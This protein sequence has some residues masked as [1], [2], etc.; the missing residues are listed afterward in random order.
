MTSRLPARTASP[1]ASCA[2]SARSRRSRPASTRPRCA[3]CSRA[4]RRRRT[5]R[6]ARRPASSASS[7]ST[8][9]ARRAAPRSSSPC[10][11]FRT[12]R[13]RRS[14]GGAATARTTT[15]TIVVCALIENGGHGGTSAAPAALKVFEQYFGKNGQL[16]TR[17]LRLMAIEAVDRRARGLRPHRAGRG[18]RAR[19][20]RSPAR[21]AAARRARRDRRLR[22]VGD[23]RDHDARRRAARRCSRQALY[24]VA[25][26]DALPR[27]A[28]RRSRHVPAP[29]A[30]DLLRDARTDDL[31]A[32]RGRGDARLEA[33]DR[34]RLLQV[35][36]V[37][38]RQGALRPRARGLPRRA[39]ALDRTPR[40][41][42]AALGYGARPDPARL[43]PAGHRHGARLHRGAR[44][45]CSS[46]PASAGRTSACSRRSRSSAA[47]AVLW[48][49]PAAG[50]NVLKP[51]QAA[52]PDRLHASGQRPAR[53][54]V[55]P[56]PVD[57]RRRRRRRCAAAACSARRRRGSTTCPSMRPTSRSRR[58][59]RS[60][61]SS[62]RR[63]C[64]CSICCR[65]ASA[66]D[67]RER[68]RPVLRDRRRR[69][70]VHVPVPGV[71]QQRDDDG[72]RADHRHPVAVRLRRRLVDDHELP[73]DRDPAGDPPAPPRRGGAREAERSSGR[74]RC[75]RSG[76]RVRRGS[77]DQRPLAVAGA[78]ELVPLLARELREG[79]DASAV[80]EGRVENAAALVWVGAPD[81]DALRA[82]D[83]A[84]RADR[85]GHRCATSCPTCSRP[86]SCACRRARAFRS[87][88]SRA[89]RAQAR[90]GRHGARCAAARASARRLRRA[91]PLVLE[92]ERDHRARRSS[93]PASTCRC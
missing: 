22:P 24:A 78:R 7:R 56:A 73:G 30:P 67:R 72:D 46:S 1:R 84:R 36:A 15:P 53:R 18:R 14:R 29:L 50:V 60:A 38:V 68:A 26:G 57:H 61:A 37:R 42:L 25:G 89:R 16:T 87:T 55:Q 9:P 59:P 65:L 85:R 66:E 81:E 63:S 64:C 41:P 23:R 69:H 82:A 5:H 49:L 91:D 31:R 4:S 13:T 19:R 35:P 71:R 12:R 88:R 40:A 3:T 17:H 58:S 45:A 75:S 43:R 2:A 20:C 74:W 52:A 86:T 76:A 48:L 28:V 27:R 44:R 54:D 33:L 90:R 92:E 77:G 83:R 62:A 32:R 47:L 80:V 11:A 79:G 10:P 39:L 34:R 93:S 70:R 51:Y 8:S 21:L 6:S